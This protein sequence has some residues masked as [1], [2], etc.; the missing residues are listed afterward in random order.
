MNAPT[1]GGGQRGATKCFGNFAFS[2]GLGGLLLGGLA[3]APQKVFAMSALVSATL[4]SV[5]ICSAEGCTDLFAESRLCGYCNLA[6][7]VWVVQGVV[8]GDHD[9]PVTAHP[10]EPLHARMPLTSCKCDYHRSAPPS[11]TN[12]SRLA[13]IDLRVPEA[14]LALLVQRMSN[15][16]YHWFP[17]SPRKSDSSR[18]GY[19]FK[20]KHS[21]LFRP[22]MTRGTAHGG[23]IPPQPTMTSTHRPQHTCLAR[24]KAVCAQ[25]LA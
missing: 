6:Q 9:A 1:L 3:A 17:T 2:G 5:A 15:F 11:C 16:P 22:H 24:R 19:D 8:G 4:A 23:S 10:K 14:T 18:T 20:D 13:A 12:V 21:F 7:D 25:L